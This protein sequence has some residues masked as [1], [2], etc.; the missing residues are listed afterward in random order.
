MH[1]YGTIRKEE[2]FSYSQFPR[3]KRQVTHCTQDG[4]R[5]YQAWARGRHS[6]VET[7]ATY[8]TVD[9]MGRSRNKQQGKK[10]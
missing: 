9:S 4:T 7:Q 8:F 2:I 10:A 5:E 6:R 1:R 3:N